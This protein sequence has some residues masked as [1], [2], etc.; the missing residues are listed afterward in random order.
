MKL[1]PMS[2][3]NP[4][5]VTGEQKKFQ[6]ILDLRAL[7]ATMIVPPFLPR[8]FGEKHSQNLQKSRE[9]LNSGQGRKMSYEKTLKKPNNTK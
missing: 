3:K 7:T 1:L 2:H 8:S 6:I 9:I 4:I 5:T